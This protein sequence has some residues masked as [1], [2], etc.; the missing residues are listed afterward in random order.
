MPQVLCQTV[1]FSTV[2]EMKI[3]LPVFT[4]SDECLSSP[5]ENGGTCV[6]FVSGYNCTCD[7]A[8]TGYNCET[9]TTFQILLLRSN[10]LRE[11]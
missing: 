10:E 2:Y 5:C 11:I 1:L 8:Y 4:E 3:F 6:D 7:P 9:G